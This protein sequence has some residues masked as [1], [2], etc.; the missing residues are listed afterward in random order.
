MSNFETLFVA[1]YGI[2]LLPSMIIC[3]KIAK[4]KGLNHVN[5]VLSATFLG[6]FTIPLI[7]LYKNKK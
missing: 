6:L 2:T 1:I 7:L 5:W 4:T 3:H